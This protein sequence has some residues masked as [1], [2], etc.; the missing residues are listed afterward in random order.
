MSNDILRTRI[1]EMTQLLQDMDDN[2]PQVEEEVFRRQYAKLRRLAGQIAGACGGDLSLR[3]TELVGEFYI[4]FKNQ[5]PI[6]FRDTGHFLNVARKKM[7]EILYDHA[8]KRNAQKRPASKGRV[9]ITD[10]LTDLEL[11]G[12]AAADAAPQTVLYLRQLLE[13]LEER[14]PG[15]V[16]MVEQYYYLGFTHK[17]I[18][19]IRGVQEDTIRQR[20]QFIRAWLKMQE[21]HEPG[22]A[23]Q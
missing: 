2:N 4:R 6:Q 16:E 5:E 1:G 11:N 10:I 18:A 15:D 21:S 8:R 20:L 13:R 7:K 3:P 14:N 19:Q 22:G 17:E 23:V 9:S 12:L